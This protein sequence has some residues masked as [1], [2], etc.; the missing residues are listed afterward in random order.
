MSPKKQYTRQALI[1]M[2]EAQRERLA[3]LSEE[4]GVSQAEVL[5]LCIDNVTS[6]EL[7]QMLV[8]AHQRRAEEVMKG[9]VNGSQV[10]F[11]DNKPKG[12]RRQRP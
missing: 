8:K 7:L 2:S 5:R 1:A 11:I 9:Q 3:R 10:T 4:V 6:A 12:R